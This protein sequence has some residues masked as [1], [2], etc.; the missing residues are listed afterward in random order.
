MIDFSEMQ[1]FYID[2]TSVTDITSISGS[3]IKNLLI[4][5]CDIQDLEPIY[6]LPALNH[7]SVSNRER[8]DETRLSCD[9]SSR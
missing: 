7:L 8:L 9:V 3:N 1:N 6:T 4:S 5:G 2:N